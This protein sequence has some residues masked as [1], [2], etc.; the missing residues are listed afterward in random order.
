MMLE[1][2]TGRCHVQV[3]RRRTKKDWAQVTKDR[4]DRYDPEADSI[5]PGMDN[6][7]THPKSGVVRR[8][9]TFEAV[10]ERHAQA[11]LTQ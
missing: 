10:F 6:L 4:V 9:G 11:R 5:T 2:L 7:S 1:P 3:T 8:L